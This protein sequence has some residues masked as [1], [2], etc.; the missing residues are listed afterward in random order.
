MNKTITLAL[1][2][3]TMV[4]VGSSRSQFSGK[5]VLFLRFEKKIIKQANL[6]A[7]SIFS[8]YCR[9][10]CPKPSRFHSYQVDMVLQ[11]SVIGFEPVG[12]NKAIFDAS[13]AANAAYHQAT[14]DGASGHLTVIALASG[15]TFDTSKHILFQYRAL[16]KNTLADSA[17]V[18]ISKVDAGKSADT[19]VNSGIDTVII[20]GA[21]GNPDLGWGPVAVAVLDTTSTPTPKRFPITVVIDSVQLR[22]DSVGSSGVSLVGGDSASVRSADFQ[23]IIDTSAVR[24]LQVMP[25][26]TS[27]TISSS[28]SG[29][30]L[31]VRYASTIPIHSVEYLFAIVLSA[32]KRS[33]TLCS[34]ISAPNF[35]VT[36][37]DELV[38][39]VGYHLGAVCVEGMRD[40][41]NASVRSDESGNR[42]SI[43]VE[44]GIAHLVRRSL[45]VDMHS[46]ADLYDLGGRL[47]EQA[48]IAGTNS[49][50]MRI[51][52]SGC[53]IVRITNERGEVEQ[54]F[55]ISVVH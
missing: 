30:T 32:K 28:M 53:F 3:L 16:V 22:S 4:G 21:S 45:D 34:V 48:M 2:L 37:P 11:N 6:P 44:H 49:A 43:A 40:T 46:T 8:V 15:S 36:N 51:P 42:W 27:S 13:V 31:R 14:Y 39:Q 18:L 41:S 55:R 29:D 25:S 50:D 52:A 17:S 19:S 5:N 33:D 38:S 24:L 26:V 23:C 7:D 54:V 10:Q 1:L 35:Q 20:E 12:D 47:I 9:L